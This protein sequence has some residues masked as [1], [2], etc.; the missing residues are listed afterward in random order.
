MRQLLMQLFTTLNNAT[1]YRTLSSTTA[2][3]CSQTVTSTHAY[4]TIQNKNRLA[5]S[6]VL[7]MHDAVAFRPVSR[8]H[9]PVRPSLQIHPTTTTTHTRSS[10][11][12]KSYAGPV[13]RGVAKRRTQNAA[14]AV[15]AHTAVHHTAAV[16]KHSFHA[17]T[18][19]Q[20][21]GRKSRHPQAHSHPC[22]YSCSNA[23]LQL[24]LP[25]SRCPRSCTCTLLWCHGMLPN[26]SS[27]ELGIF[28][29]KALHPLTTLS[30]NTYPSTICATNTTLSPTQ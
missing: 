18:N 2:A 28:P 14:R 4:C 7:A 11:N 13:W 23:I 20:Y 6:P 10:A 9:L 25:R 15:P 26:R 8:S 19:I 24:S 29:S 21:P 16:F 27:A 22:N 5:H 3:Q 1:Q 12:C 17:S 30:L